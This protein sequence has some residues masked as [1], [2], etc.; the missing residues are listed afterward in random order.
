VFEGELLELI[1]GQL[2]V[3]EPKGSY[4]RSVTT[5]TPPDSVVPLAF[6]SSRIAVA[7]LLP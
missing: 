6:A 4:Q 5:V 1:G 7:D 2:I 3:A